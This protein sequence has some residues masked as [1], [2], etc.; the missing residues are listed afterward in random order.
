MRK[1]AIDDPNAFYARIEQRNEERRVEDDERHLMAVLVVA[2][3]AE[4]VAQG[5]MALVPGAAFNGT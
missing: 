5:V 4:D 2:T 1:L 3:Q